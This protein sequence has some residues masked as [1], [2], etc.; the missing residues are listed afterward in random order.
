[1]D[2]SK[3]KNQGQNPSSKKK[4]KLTPAILFFFLPAIIG[5][6]SFYFYS[7]L[8]TRDPAPIA[9]TD[10]VKVTQQKPP[11]SVVTAQTSEPEVPELTTLSAKQD[12]IQ[13]DQKTESEGTDE[14]LAPL[15]TLPLPAPTQTPQTSEKISTCDKPTQQLN[16]F[17]KH[18]D[19]QPYMAAYGLH[20]TSKNHFTTLIKKLLANPPQVTRESDDLYT[21]LKNTAHFFRV[22]GK[23]NI[24]MMKGILDH[25]KGSLEQILAD[26]YVLVTTPDC[27]MTPYCSGIDK[28]ALYE[29]ACFFL[30]TMGGRL[31]LFRRDSLSRMVVTYYA[32]LL[33][34]LANTENNN[35]HGIALKP[36][37]DMLIA[38]METGGSTLKQLEYYLDKLYDLKEKYQ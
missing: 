14:V 11:E 9:S 37:V 19:R 38:E 1:M 35:R 8:K 30:N 20:S 18:L 23:D 3:E 17:Y 2:P 34:D 33:V 7:G 6:F 4:S 32:I 21:I 15:P 13:S 26:Y 10:A 16:E 28:G 27:G 24:L 22:S 25:E 29:Y 5:G 31:Y 12:T 36:A